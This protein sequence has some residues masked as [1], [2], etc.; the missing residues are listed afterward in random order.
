MG[1]AAHFRWPHTL[2]LAADDT[3]IDGGVQQ[4]INTRT[5]EFVF[6]SVQ[7]CRAAK[8]YCDPIKVLGL[9]HRAHFIHHFTSLLPH[10][11]A[12]VRLLKGFATT[13]VPEETNL[14]AQNYIP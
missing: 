6:F 4:L 8:K 1:S 2:A 5:V 7:C 12:F 9:E 11:S 14:E 10:S 3:N 13:K